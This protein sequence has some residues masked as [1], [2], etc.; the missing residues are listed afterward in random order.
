MKTDFTSTLKASTC[1]EVEV[2]EDEQGELQTCCI[3]S[4]ITSAH[5]KELKFY[6]ASL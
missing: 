2:V 4:L 5:N 6:E 1:P 3:K